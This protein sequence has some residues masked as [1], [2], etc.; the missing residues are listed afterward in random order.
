MFFF[1]K[2]ALE[3]NVA[4]LLEKN[5]FDLKEKT[6]KLN[7]LHEITLKNELDRVKAA[8]DQKEVKFFFLS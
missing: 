4:L 6:D 3:S 7:A 2:I 8:H 5:E 1:L